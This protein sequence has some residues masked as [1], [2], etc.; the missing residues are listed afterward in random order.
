MT[1][2]ITG[3]REL[4][5]TFNTFVLDQWGVLHFGIDAPAYVIDTLKHLKALGKDVVVLS[6]SGKGAQYSEDRMTRL[7]ITRDLYD[8]ILTSGEMVR[9]GIQSH[10]GPIF[11]GLGRKCFIIS[12]NNDR[13]T[14]EGLDV[15]V[16]DDFHDADFILMINCDYKTRTL[17]SYD[18]MLKD[19][20][21]RQLPMICANPDT[22]VVEGDQV[23]YGPGRV[24]LRYEDM[25]GKVHFIG[26]P[27]SAVFAHALSLVPNAVEGT[28]IMIGDTMEHDIKGGHNMGFATCLTV[29]GA[30]AQTFAGVSH[31]TACQALSEEFG[32]T[33]SYVVDKFS[34]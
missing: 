24:A 2:S 27:H 23:F 18:E 14:V 13:S 15:E 12:T 3:I 32:L 1:K 21:A 10:A 5:E 22:L 16:V 34:W 28:T 11:E 17:E 25:G 8:H 6:N 30:H 9:Q 26:K 4:A 7:G 33:P 29:T 19:C 20:A 31:E